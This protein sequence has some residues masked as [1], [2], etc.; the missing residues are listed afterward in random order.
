MIR[1]PSSLLSVSRAMEVEATQDMRISLSQLIK[2]LLRV[3][4]DD[5]ICDSLWENG[6][7][8]RS[9]CDDFSILMLLIVFWTSYRNNAVKF[10]TAAPEIAKDSKSSL[11]DLENIKHVLSGLS[12]SI[13]SAI[14]GLKQSTPHILHSKSL[15]SLP[16]E[17]LATILE[18]RIE[19]CKIRWRHYL[20]QTLSL[21]CQR[22]RRIVLQSPRS[23]SYID[24]NDNMSYARACLDRS[25]SVGLS[26]SFS[27]MS[28]S[29]PLRFL[30]AIVP[31]SARW[32]NLSITFIEQHPYTRTSAFCRSK[33][34]Q[35]LH[36]PSLRSLCLMAS[37][38]NVE[39]D[40]YHFY[41]SWDMP[42][43]RQ[44]EMNKVPRRFIA[45]T[46]TSV[47]Y[48]LRNIGNTLYED[49]DAFAQIQRL[50]PFL[51]AFPALVELEVAI[52]LWGARGLEQM[53]SL[54]LPHLTRLRVDASSCGSTTAGLFMAK[55]QA[56]L[57]RKL[58]IV[59]PKCNG[60]DIRI[61]DF[62][63]CDNYPALK[64]LICRMIEHEN[65]DR[66]PLI[67]LPFEK[68]KKTIIWNE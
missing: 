6:I 10:W 12:K 11:R 2:I 36:L 60:D 65:D 15:A 54:Q 50:G 56:P 1:H 42:N 25:G 44:L 5:Q 53:P 62:F 39:S 3:K 45:P 59:M 17:L 43:L 51:S 49:P 41:E 14:T 13:D 32:E 64:D 55:L 24:N 20:I 18:Y 63:P 48:S 27:I 40:I 38:G 66:G 4:D 9:V 52:C 30:D 61:L 29:N 57:L 34:L 28:Y 58:E 68:L 26:V 37:P 31:H 23:W 33:L 35:N 67:S 7:I 19:T 16:D 22:F 8:N 46:V 47:R 21:V